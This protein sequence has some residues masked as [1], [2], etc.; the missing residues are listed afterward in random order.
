MGG[1]GLEIGAAIGL[2]DG[3]AVASR[4]QW[5]GRRVG[6]VQ[7]DV[8]GTRRVLLSARRPC[9]QQGACYLDAAVQNQ[10]KSLHYRTIQ[11][12]RTRDA[13]SFPN[14]LRAFEA[15]SSASCS[16]R[17]SACSCR[18]NSRSISA[19]SSPAAVPSSTEERLLTA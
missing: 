16:S 15:L 19:S 13:Y 17:C 10:I 1:S 6:A 3:R 18:F 14:F 11:K 5:R 8:Q 12:Q 2:T 9:R 7:Q 4:K